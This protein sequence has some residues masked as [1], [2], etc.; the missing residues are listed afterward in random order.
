MDNDEYHAIIPNTCYDLILNTVSVA[1]V[2][3][4]TTAVGANPNLHIMGPHNAGDANMETDWMHR[5][6]SFIIL[7]HQNTYFGFVPQRRLRLGSVHKLLF[8]LIAAEIIVMKYKKTNNDDNGTAYV[9]FCLA[10]VSALDTQCCLM[11]DMYWT[12][13]SLKEPL[14]DYT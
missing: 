12:N 10:K 1:T 4:I 7:M 6:V 5:I 9:Q 11:V 8:I 14:L 13:I 2:T 3:T